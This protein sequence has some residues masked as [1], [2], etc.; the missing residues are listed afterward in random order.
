VKLGIMVTTDRHL[1]QVCG[2]T[3]AAIAGGHTVS[4]FATDEGTRLLADGRFAA[5]GALAGVTMSYCDHNAQ[6]YG[7]RPPGLPEA[8][9]QGSQLENAIMC[10]TSDKVLML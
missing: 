1:E 4:I 8:V 7:A 5:L 2:L 6:R 3:R 10:S 9:V